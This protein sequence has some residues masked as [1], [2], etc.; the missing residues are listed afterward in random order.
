MKNR[1]NYFVSNKNVLTWLMALCM[2]GSAVTRIVFVGMKGID[3]TA[4]VWSQI[5]LP[6]AAGVLF[7]LIVLLSGKEQFYKTAIPSG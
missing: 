4:Q 3:S 2:L 6:I 7:A 5:V 1:T